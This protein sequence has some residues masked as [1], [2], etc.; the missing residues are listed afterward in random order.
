MADLLNEKYTMRRSSWGVVVRR[1]DDVS[2]FLEVDRS[3]FQH[4]IF[5][6]KEFYIRVFVRE[7]FL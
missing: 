2:N 3:G 4:A 7:H 1:V 5:I 6:S